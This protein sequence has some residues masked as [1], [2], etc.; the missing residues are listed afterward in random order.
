MLCAIC[1]LGALQA[2]LAELR[3]LVE[4]LT[5]KNRHLAEE[6]SEAN[7]AQDTSHTQLLA[8]QVCACWTAAFAN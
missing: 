6:L 4:S 7:R 1:C 8:L 2:E 5:R 3:S